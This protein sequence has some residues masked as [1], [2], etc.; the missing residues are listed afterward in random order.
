MMPLDQLPRTD[1][2]TVCG[3]NATVHIPAAPNGRW[4]WKTEFFYA[5]D[6][7]ERALYD[8]GFIRV[9]FEISDKYGSPDAVSL[10]HAFY[11][12]MM[13]RYGGAGLSDKAILAGFSRGGLY[14]FNFALSYPALVEK[15]WLDAPVL[16]LRSWPRTDPAYG[17]GALHAEV[18]AEYGFADEE[19]FRAYDGY[20]VC[21]LADY[22]ALHIP[23]LL[24]AG[25][26][27]SVVAF[28]ENAGVMLDY[29]LAHDIPLAYYIKMGID[30]H[31]HG[32]GCNAGIDWKGRPYPTE[33][34]AYTSAHP[35]STPDAPVII[36]NE[37]T[38]PLAFFA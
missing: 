32:F 25:D 8:R 30:H 4:I 14:A 1:S 31:P 13:T 6:E 34:T 15:L 12:E 3:Y 18:K 5:F 19:A 21:R 36:P 7:V 16:D 29:A 24:I 23:T 28:S 10:M 2:F 11:E 26:S 38:L 33:I 17:E 9:Y 22:F 27:D 37:A 20:P 35:G